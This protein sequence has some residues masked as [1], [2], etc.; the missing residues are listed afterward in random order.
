MNR[1]V[2]DTDVIVAAMRS[3]SGASAALLDAA[4][5]RRLTMLASVPLFFEY[6]AKCT[7]PVHWTAAGLSRKQSEIFVDG[8]VALIEP[9]KTHFLWRP[10]LRD[11]ND[12]MVLEV[13]VNGGAEAIVTFNLRDY[14]TVSEKFNI[15]VII[16]AVAI[17]RVRNE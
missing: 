7:S 11:P 6:E 10:M 1:F 5:N 12:E 3:P 9:V 4:L 17:R 13:A 14:G 16:P 8:L 2:L 15:E